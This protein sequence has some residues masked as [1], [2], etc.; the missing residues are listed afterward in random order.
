MTWN[1]DNIKESYILVEYNLLK[2]FKHCRTTLFR[3]LY[4]KKDGFWS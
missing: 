4:D 1:L 3:T 2:T